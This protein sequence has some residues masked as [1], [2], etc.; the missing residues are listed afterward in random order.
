MA[1]AARMSPPGGAAT[2]LDAQPAQCG[3]YSRRAVRGDNGPAFAI[4]GGDLFDGS[5]RHLIDVG[6]YL[7]G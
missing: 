7:G 2:D 5:G 4:V 3:T 1:R 6:W